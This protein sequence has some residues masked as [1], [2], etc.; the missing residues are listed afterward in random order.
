MHLR[1]CEKYPFKSILYSCNQ[2]AFQTPTD[3]MLQ[4]GA[5]CNKISS[6]SSLD[7]VTTRTRIERIIRTDNCRA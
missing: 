2:N 7:L 1:F 3:G 4:S 5:S 6:E